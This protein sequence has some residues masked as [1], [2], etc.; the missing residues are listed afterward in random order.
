[1]ET[2]CPWLVQRLGLTDQV[3]STSLVKETQIWW[4]SPEQ[5]WWNRSPPYTG[6]RSFNHS[7]MFSSQIGTTLLLAFHNQENQA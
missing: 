4:K 3:H 1:M 5:I 2:H 7:D 6:R